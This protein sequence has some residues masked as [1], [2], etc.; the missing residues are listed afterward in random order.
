[1]AV[2]VAV[3]RLGDGLAV[4]HLGLAD[5]GLD[6]V[7]A[8]HA[9]DQH[10][11]VQ[12][13]HARDHRLAGVVIGAD[14]EGRILVGEGLHRLA[15]LVLIGLGLRLDRDVDDRL[16]E[17]HPLEDDRVVPV[18]QRVSGGGV[19][20]AEA[21]DDVTRHGGLEVLAVVGVHQEDAAE[22]LALL[23]G[24]VVDLV[25]LVDLTRVDPE[26]GELAERVGDDLE[27]QRGEALVGGRPGDLGRRRACSSP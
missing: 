15:E 26:V 21:G 9:V 22:S 7:L 16:G 23:L 2:L 1:M 3:D 25:A 19:L 27:R 17:L 4:G 24:G 11:E 12:L 18:A 13:A 8:L 14:A 6:V 5:G 20:E 10:L